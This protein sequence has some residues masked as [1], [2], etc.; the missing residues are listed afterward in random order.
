MSTITRFIGRREL[1]NELGVSKTTIL[2]WT[3][4]RGFPQPL[5][6]SG[7]V[8]IYD[9]DDIKRWLRSEPVAEGQL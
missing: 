8:P 9:R 5:Q 6:N 3:A 7:Q 4:E 2:R 1:L